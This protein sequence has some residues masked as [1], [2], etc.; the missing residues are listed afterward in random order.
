MLIE[1][2]SSNLVSCS[3]F[4]PLGYTVVPT[5]GRQEQII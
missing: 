5:L 1:V 3:T 4:G 2:A